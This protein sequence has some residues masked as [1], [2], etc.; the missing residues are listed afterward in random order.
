[1]RDFVLADDDFDR[2]LRGDVATTNAGFESRTAIHQITF[3]TCEEVANF[4]AHSELN[5]YVIDAF[6]SL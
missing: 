3:Q 1:M 6:I 2:S 5:L 4:P